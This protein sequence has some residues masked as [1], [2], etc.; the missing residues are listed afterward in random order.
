MRKLLAALVSAVIACSSNGPAAPRPQLDCSA[1]TD[2]TQTGRAPDHAGTVCASGVPLSSGVSTF[3]LDPHLDQETGEERGALLVHYQV[4][5]VVG[6]DVYV[7]VKTG[8]YVSC[9]PAGSRKPFPCGPDAWGQQVWNEQHLVWQGGKLVS[10][11]TVPTDW[12]PPPNRGTSAGTASIA[13]W[14]PVFHAVVS[15]DSLWMP[16]GSGGV[17]Q[18]DRA[19]G[20]VRATISP[21]GSNVNVF[22][23][24]PLT[25]TSSGDILYTAIEL[26]PTNPWGDNDPAGFLVRV[27]GG[28]PTPIPWASL[29]PGAPNPQNTCEGTYPNPNGQPLPP[30]TASGAVQPAPPVRCGIQRPALNAAP[31]V[32]A[33][34]TIFVASRS[35]RV[36]RYAYIVAVNP[37]D[38]SPRWASSMRDILED[39]CG[40][41]V[42]A[43]NNPGNCTSAAPRGVDPETGT[44][45]A[46]FI[47]DQGSS[48]PVA[49]PD[50]GVIFGALTNYN[51]FRGHLFKF[52]S[53]GRPAG[54]FDFGWD[55]TPA[56]FPHDGTYSIVLKD[57]HYLTN[58]PYYITQLSADL[59]V[60]WRFVSSNTQ[61]CARQAN[62][63]I[64]CVDDGQ[65][66]NGFEWCINSVAVDRDG[67]VYANSEDGNLYAIGP[68]GVF[69]NRVF[70]DRA[71]GAAYTP[72]SM[73]SKGRLYAQNAGKMYAFSGTQ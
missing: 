73:D 19:T 33:D 48:S 67:T 53:D 49:L 47:S 63:Q 61:S 41:T 8:S 9:T 6:D 28:V 54:T 10:T 40:V 71:L 27:R 31:A 22:V 32:G 66:G 16:A 56:W 64:S 29:V 17:M 70:L 14:E 58:G 39:G 18:L 13:D 35:H 30:L 43:D 69:K 23:A 45:P 59:H 42:P 1:T 44:R 50:G 7:A 51:G 36:A 72:I 60:E 25:A 37:A 46:G 4:P 12:K 5:L 20:Q 65:H 15:G 2:W 34:G 3:V 52:A 62:G 11:W 24:G 55:I 38:L 68:G 26:D 21:F 57:N